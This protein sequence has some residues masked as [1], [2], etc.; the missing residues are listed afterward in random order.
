MGYIKMKATEEK[1]KKMREYA[2]THR[3]QFNEYQRKYVEKLKEEA[4]KIPT[5]NYKARIDKAIK[6]IKTHDLYHPT[7]EVILLNILK[8]SDK[9]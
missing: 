2:R 1:K 8:G 3:E 6:F 9:E 4:K 7:N 5:T